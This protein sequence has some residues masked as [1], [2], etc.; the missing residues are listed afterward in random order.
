M[1]I[2]VSI[3]A[4]L[5]C[6]ATFAQK[7]GRDKSATRILKVDNDIYMIQ[8]KGG[9]I[10]LSV[11]DDGVFMIDDQFADSTV[12]IM[13]LIA[14]KSDK[15]VEFLINTHHHGDHT[16]G[17]YNMQ[18]HG[19]TIVAHENVRVRLEETIRSA[20]EKSESLSV[21]M[22]PVITFDNDMTFYYNNEEISVIHLKNAHTD[23]D[24]IVYFKNSNVLHTGDIFF[25]NKYPYIDL[26]HGGTVEG[27]IA[28]LDQI[29][30]MI[31]N[32]TKIIPG[33]GEMAFKADVS[34]A[35]SMLAGLYKNVSYQYVNKKTEAEI[36]AMRDFTKPYDD[37]GFGDG[38]IST[39]KMLQTL[40]N[41]V[42]AD[43]GVIDNRSM[44]EQL[45]EKVRL[46][47]EKNKGGGL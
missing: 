28:A 4:L 43:R 34:Y 45:Q 38:F 25:K 39:E 36:I 16:G 44:E 35:S 42:K 2:K 26:T 31:D 18:A 17:N 14:E 1:K 47:Q 32:E 10:G 30:S 11:G 7:D 13:E 5:F 19:A 29:L 21:Q 46:Q 20:T 22:L 6:L 33:H 12:E 37:L 24:A 3:T 15:P 8:G 41:Q 40:Y 27:Y 23:G 9:N